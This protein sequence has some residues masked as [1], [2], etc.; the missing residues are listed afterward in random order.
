MSFEEIKDCDATLTED[1]SAQASSMDQLSKE[2]VV[3]SSSLLL[4]SQQ[5]DIDKKQKQVV[6]NKKNNDKKEVT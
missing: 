6:K 3:P 4:S 5:F 2:F 1:I